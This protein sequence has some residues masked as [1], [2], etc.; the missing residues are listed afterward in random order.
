MFGMTRN[1]LRRLPA[2]K[3]LSIDA[4]ILIILANTHVLLDACHVVTCC[5]TIDGFGCGSIQIVASYRS[6]ASWQPT[7]EH[8]SCVWGFADVLGVMPGSCFSL[9]LSPGCSVKYPGYRFSHLL[10]LKNSM[11]FAKLQVIDWAFS[12][13]PFI[14]FCIVIFIVFF[15]TWEAQL[16]QQGT[17]RFHDICSDAS[18]H[19][20]FDAEQSPA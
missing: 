20:A 17:H 19:T 5:D 7:P 2:E 16:M 11:L 6:I 8:C 13:F 12:A 14:S 10:L 1:V 18:K 15:L 3:S 9:V 4:P